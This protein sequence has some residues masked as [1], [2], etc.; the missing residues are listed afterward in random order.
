MKSKKP[1]I[2]LDNSPEAQEA[3]RLQ[4]YSLDHQEYLDGK[5]YQQKT[6]TTKEAKEGIKLEKAAKKSP[7]YKEAAR[8][9]ETLDAAHNS[10]PTAQNSSKLKQLFKKFRK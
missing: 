7:D 9:K 8:L 1:K 5:K 4:A 10:V 6:T 2:Y 3:R